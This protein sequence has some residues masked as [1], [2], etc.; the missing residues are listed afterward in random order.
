MNSIDK[1]HNNTFFVPAVPEQVVMRKQTFPKYCSILLLFLFFCAAIACSTENTSDTNIQNAPEES[2]KSISKNLN[3]NSAVS[4]ELSIQVSPSEAIHS[5]ILGLTA[6]GFNIE[7]AKIEWLVNG[8]RVA[9]QE[10][11]KQFEAAGTNKGDTVQARA[12][13]DDQEILS[14]IVT[15][16][17]A[18]PELTRVKI[19]PE[20]FSPGD[21]VYIDAAAADIDGDDVSI[22]Y[23]WTFNGELAGSGREINT[24][25]KRGDKLSVKVTPYDGETYG[26]SITL[27]R[28]I[29]NLPPM[30]GGE[31]ISSFDGKTY[32]YKINAIDPDGDPLTYTLKEGPPGMTVDSASGIITWE[33]PSG[34]AGIHNITVL[35]SDSQGGE[36]LA[37]FNLKINPATPKP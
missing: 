5:S 8:S 33:V 17:N 1:K 22:S 14:N 27:N 25:I 6:K 16:V 19:M 13:I 31:S 36:L 32:T 35:I 21:R 4:D 15:V 28:E 34:D 9:S 30:I 2:R 3:K 18:P 11:P 37:P 20:V 29:R 23:E 26:R 24:E 10:T 7:D 12:I